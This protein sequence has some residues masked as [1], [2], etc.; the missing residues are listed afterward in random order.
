MALEPRLHGVDF[1]VQNIAGENCLEVPPICLIASA[2]HYL[3]KQEGNATVVVPFWPS[4]PRH[5]ANF[6]VEYKVLNGREALT[7]SLL[8]SKPFYGKILVLRMNFSHT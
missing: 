8:G 7:N 1:F 4:S 6:I 3:Q 5:L 2:L